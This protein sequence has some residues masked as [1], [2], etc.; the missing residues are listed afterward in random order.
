MT[1]QYCVSVRSNAPFCYTPLQPFSMN[2]DTPDLLPEGGEIFID[3]LTK[4]T[5]GGTELLFAV[6]ILTCV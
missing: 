1:K 2:T 6:K 3:Q 4:K 5:D